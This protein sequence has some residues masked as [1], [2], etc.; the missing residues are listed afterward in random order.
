MDARRNRLLDQ[1]R[2]YADFIFQPPP[3][4]H[5]LVLTPQVARLLLKE[6]II[7]LSGAVEDMMSTLVVAQ[8]LFAEAD[9]P[10]KKIAMLHQLARRRRDVRACDLRHDAICP[11]GDAAGET[12]AK[13]AVDYECSEPTIWRALRG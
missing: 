3:L 6:R 11:P 1:A 13:L 4:R 7:F 9:N 2:D 8:L 5:H 10:K 12:M